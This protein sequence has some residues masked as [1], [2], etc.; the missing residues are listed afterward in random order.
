MSR[1]RRHL[2][3]MFLV[4][5]IPHLSILP[6]PSSLFPMTLHPYT[7][8]TTRL[9]LTLKI[10]EQWPTLSKLFMRPY[11]STLATSRRTIFFSIHPCSVKHFIVNFLS[12]S[13]NPPFPTFIKPCPEGISP[14]V[15]RSK[16]K[17]QRNWKQDTFVKFNRWRS[18]HKHSLLY[19]SQLLACSLVGGVCLC[20]SQPIWQSVV[21][22]KVIILKY[23]YYRCLFHV[24]HSS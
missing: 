19:W 9:L 6:P 14:R 23:W 22:V 1:A 3:L 18:L 2:E 17:A 20:F 12:H 5:S 11:K 13:R 24:S 16:W 7:T 10:L 8:T 4:Q 15:F 21:T